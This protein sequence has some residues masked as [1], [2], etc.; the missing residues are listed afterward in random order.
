MVA[1]FHREV[2]VASPDIGSLTENPK[3]CFSNEVSICPLVSGERNTSP[4]QNQF[5]VGSYNESKLD[6]THMMVFGE[7][8][9]KMFSQSADGM[10][11]FPADNSE[12]GQ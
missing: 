2:Y 6:K 10:C 4:K 11:C 5:Y 3:V 7:E 12:K 9:R 8:R 1:A